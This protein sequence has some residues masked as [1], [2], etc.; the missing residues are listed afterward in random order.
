M[1]VKITKVKAL[2]TEEA[3]IRELWAVRSCDPAQALAWWLLLCVSL[4]LNAKLLLCTLC[5]KK[6]ETLKEQCGNGGF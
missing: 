2:Q 3:V 5:L 6:I 1:D 4:E